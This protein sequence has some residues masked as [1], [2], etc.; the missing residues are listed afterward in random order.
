MDPHT[1]KAATCKCSVRPAT[2]KKQ[3]R[4]GFISG[5]SPFSFELSYIMG[6]LL[7]MPSSQPLLDLRHELF[8]ALKG[9]LQSICS[10]ENAMSCNKPNNLGAFELCFLF[11]PCEQCEADQWL[12]ALR[13]QALTAPHAAGLN[14]ALDSTENPHSLALGGDLTGVQH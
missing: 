4:L 9:G 6:S 3:Y 1:D 13:D 7:W 8:Q 5:F 14:T 12:P 10:N 11:F 2:K